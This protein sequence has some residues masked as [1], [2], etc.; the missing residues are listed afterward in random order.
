MFYSIK[1]ILKYYVS[2]LNKKRECLKTLPFMIFIDF[3]P[4]P[5]GWK[6]LKTNPPFSVGARMIFGERE[7]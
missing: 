4:L 5:K 3:L 2:I 1:R 7:F 6:P